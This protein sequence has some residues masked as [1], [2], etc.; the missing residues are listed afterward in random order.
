MTDSAHRFPHVKKRRYPGDEVGSILHG[1]KALKKCC[2]KQSDPKK[3]AIPP[4]TDV[5]N[6]MS[7]VVGKASNEK[8]HENGDF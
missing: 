1:T 5:P 2:S 3:M 6:F 4:K 7:L 8:I